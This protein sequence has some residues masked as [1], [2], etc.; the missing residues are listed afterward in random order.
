MPILLKHYNLLPLKKQPKKISL[1][2]F[3]LSLALAI[4]GL[5]VQNNLS[6]EAVKS[7]PV[8]KKQSVYFG[9]NY[10]AKQLSK[11]A[12]LAPDCVR[13]LVRKHTATKRG[14]FDAL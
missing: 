11:E 9:D 7:D 4:I 8:S 12:L 6:G 2:V 14:A 3:G 13:C 10:E 5:F 1:W